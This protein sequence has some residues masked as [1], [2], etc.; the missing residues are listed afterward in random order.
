MVG[1]VRDKSI[2]TRT[3]RARLPRQ[4]EPHWLTLLP[5]RAH[6]GY[7]R[8]PEAPTGRW[9][10]RQ[11]ID[12]RYRIVALGQ[13]DDVEGV[14]LDFSRAEAMAR[15]MIDAPATAGR[16]ITVRQ[17][18][19]DYIEHKRAS[20]QPVADLT[21]RLR[22]HALP[23]LG[24]VVVAELTAE[25]LR[26]WL[27]TMA[28][29]PAMTRPRDG[30]QGWRP[31]P[32]TAEE[33]RARRATANRVLNMLR[34]ALN[35]AHDEGRVPSAAAWG[36]RL[37]GFRGVDVARIRFLTVAECQRLL[38]AA[39]PDFR[40][41]IRGA[42]ETGCRYGELAAL[43]VADLHANTLHI[44]QSKSGRPR[45]VHLTPDGTAFFKQLVAGR[46][47]ADAMFRRDDGEAWGKSEQ[48]RPLRA[49]C[50]AAR[51]EPAVSFH[52]L[53]HT[54]ASLCAMS[55]MSLQVLGA[56]L[57]HADGRMTSRYAHLAPSHVADE[58][59]ERAPR[60]GA[61]APGVVPIR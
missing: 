52:I 16:R 7:Q 26:R 13:A 32:A 39:P 54:Y 40:N 3:A 61:V 11:L 48:A 59:A 31:E 12:S 38:N 44:R 37:K 23:T 60:F 35:Y 15:A 5:G 53:R 21:S 56:N 50:A 45:Y 27:A 8:R 4:R 25:R 43:E 34:A 57:G 58:V 14:G 55:G 42:V 36:R 20:G 10:L 24:D 2:R 1:V 51:I 19:Q 18:V 6:I 49:A 30:R 47:G 28:S 29:M 33:V 41:L 9:V 22:A 17:A 46:A